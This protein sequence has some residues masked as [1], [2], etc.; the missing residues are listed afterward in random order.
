MQNPC[1]WPIIVAF[2]VDFREVGHSSKSG[3]LRLLELNR[4]LISKST[5]N[6]EKK[7]SKES[8]RDSCG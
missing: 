6:E 7:D 3:R 1:I 8:T 4:Y 5:S 2:L